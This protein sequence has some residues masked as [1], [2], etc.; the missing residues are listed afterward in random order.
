MKKYNY[1]SIIILFFSFSSCLVPRRS[2]EK[3]KTTAPP[4]YSQAKYWAALPT[5][6]DSAD[7]VPYGSNLKDGQANAKVDV[8][9]IYPT[10]YLTGRKWN[11][12]VNNE[13][14]NRKIDRSTIRHQAS[15][16]NGSCKVYA[17]RYRQAVL[18][19]F[20]KI[21]GD[22]GKALDFAYQDVK[23]HLNII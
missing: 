16:F 12:D 5:K 8:F 6:K 1:I 4:D 9:F 10:I 13:K 7:A 20:T 3:G 18:S 22:G 15:V 23:K 21:N 17:P 14:L 19:A 11:A 2:F